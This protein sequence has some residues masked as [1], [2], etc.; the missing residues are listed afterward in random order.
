MSY[1]FSGFVAQDFGYDLSRGLRKRDVWYDK[2]W[3]R[4]RR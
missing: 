3:N 2:L 4:T 1:C